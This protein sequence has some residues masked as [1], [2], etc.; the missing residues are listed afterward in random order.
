MLLTWDLCSGIK[1][2][3]HDFAKEQAPYIRK[4]ISKQKTN[5]PLTEIEKRVISSFNKR[6]WEKH[7]YLKEDYSRAR[8]LA[9]EIIRKKYESPHK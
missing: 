3:F 1:L 5:K 6:F 7:A 4:V 8:T 2:A 9:E